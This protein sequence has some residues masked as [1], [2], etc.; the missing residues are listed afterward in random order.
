MKLLDM[1]DREDRDLLTIG[2]DARMP[3][4]TPVIESAKAAEA[5]LLDGMEATQYHSLGYPA[6]WERRRQL[7]EN[8]TAPLTFDTIQE[9]LYP[10]MLRVQGPWHLVDLLNV[11]QPVIVDGRTHSRPNEF[12]DYERQHARRLESDTESDRLS[13]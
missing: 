12:F 1:L 5:R 8:T 6:T 4:L 11:D 3:D 13:D 10:R 7:P 9:A 2:P